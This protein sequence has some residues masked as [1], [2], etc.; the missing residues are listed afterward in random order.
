LIDIG[1][2]HV[3][4]WS[5]DHLLEKLQDRIGGFHLHNNDGSDDSHDWLDE[6]TMDVEH[7][8]SLIRDHTKCSDLVLEYGSL[9]GK[10]LQD[11]MRDVSRILLYQQ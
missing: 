8:L 3:T 9:Q 2:V 5:L 1:H 7:A 10:T 4:N 6:G 11:L